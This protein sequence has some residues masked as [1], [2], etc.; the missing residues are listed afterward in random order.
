MVEPQPLV[1]PAPVSSEG[2]V[3]FMAERY[4]HV[5]QGDLEVTVYHAGYY[6]EA[7]VRRNHETEPSTTVLTE[8]I[9]LEPTLQAWLKDLLD[10]AQ[11]GES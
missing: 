7:E 6:L 3:L 4:V 1:A 2:S 9:T 10:R 11:K 8:R 5:E